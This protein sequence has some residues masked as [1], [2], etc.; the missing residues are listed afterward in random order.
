MSHT[1]IE[2]EIK[3][4][5]KLGLGLAELWTYRELFYF[6]TWRDIKVKY[7]QALLGFAWAILQP[8]FMM[9]IFTFFFSKALKVPSDDIPYPIFVYS[10]LILW[11]IF[12]TGLSGAGNS[13]VANANIIKKIYFPRLI[14]PVSAIL[15]SLFDFL[16]AFIVFVGLFIYY[17][18]G[19]DISKVVFF[20]PL[21]VVITTLTA[22]GAGTLL[23]A[24]NIKYRDFRYLIPFIIQVLLFA[25]PVIYPVSIL[26]EEWMKYVMALNP[27]FGAIELFRSG[28]TNNAINLNLLAISTVSCFVLL[29]TGLFYFRKTEAYFADIA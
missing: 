27:M 15:V 13:M 29:I 4:R 11:N 20:M 28:I 23:A 26:P 24:L 12:A 14:I 6:F 21:G 22:F 17:K 9:L 25:T 8:L 16:M 19:V 5:E 7:K 10:G 18:Q 2:Y 3:P 1:N